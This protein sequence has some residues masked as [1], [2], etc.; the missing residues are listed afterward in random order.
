MCADGQ[1]TNQGRVSS[2]ELSGIPQQNGIQKA[3][4]IETRFDFTLLYEM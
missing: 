4:I 1:I 3:I 2:W